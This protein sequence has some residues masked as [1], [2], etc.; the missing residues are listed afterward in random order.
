MP[1][2]CC[3]WRFVAGALDLA[4]R[5]TN[6]PGAKTLQTKNSKAERLLENFNHR[7]FTT[8]KCRYRVSA[9]YTG[10]RENVP[11][12]ISF[13]RGS[14]TQVLCIIGSVPNQSV[15]KSEVLSFSRSRVSNI[16]APICFEAEGYLHVPSTDAAMILL[17]SQWVCL[18][19]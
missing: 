4:G 8:P 2:R 6:Q 5:L 14:L 18:L 19:S 1:Y 16:N 12:A 13:S 9:V 10:R 3:H 17:P 15:P 11:L 7:S